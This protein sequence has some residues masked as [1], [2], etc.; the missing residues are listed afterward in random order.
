[1][2]LTQWTYGQ[3][4]DNDSMLTAVALSARPVPSLLLLCYDSEGLLVRGIKECT[5]VGCT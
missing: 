5:K 4:L 2:V 1:M 3:V